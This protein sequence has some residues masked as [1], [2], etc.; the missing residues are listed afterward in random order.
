MSSFSNRGRILNRRTRSQRGRS[1]SSNQPGSDAPANPFSLH[2]DIESGPSSP[3]I[4]EDTALLHSDAESD[5]YFSSIIDRPDTGDRRTLRDQFAESVS[6][7]HQLSFPFRSQKINGPSEIYL[8]DSDDY[9]S[10]DGAESSWYDDDEITLGGDGIEEP[11]KPDHPVE[12]RNIP[13]WIGP[14]SSD[15]EHHEH[16]HRGKAAHALP[17]ARPSSNTQGTITFPQQ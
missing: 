5:D 3:A 12:H 10:D 13:D 8:G 16:G 1:L 9:L 6:L 11:L 2:K 15:D 14:L 7:I 17:H 4:N